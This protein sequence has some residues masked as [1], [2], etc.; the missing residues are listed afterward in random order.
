[1]LFPLYFKLQTPV[2][3]PPSGSFTTSRYMCIFNSD[4]MILTCPTLLVFSHCLTILCNLVFSLPPSEIL[5]DKYLIL[6][7]AQPTLKRGKGKVKNYTTPARGIGAPSWMGNR[8]E[9]P[10]ALARGCQ[11]TCLVEEC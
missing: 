5:D 4:Y 11:G 1:M 7:S 6:L 9:D 10:S 3:L 8:D 2:V